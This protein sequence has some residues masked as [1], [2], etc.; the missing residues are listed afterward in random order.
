MKLLN[1]S[2]HP[3]SG[4]SEEQKR[5]WKVFDIPFPAVPAEAGEAEVASLANSIA[6]QVM[7][8]YRRFPF[9]A[10]TIQGEFSLCY[11]LLGKLAKWLSANNISIA[12]PT[13]ERKVVG[14]NGKKVSE[15]EFVR[16]RMLSPAFLFN[17][18]EVENE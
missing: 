5:G 11:L 14:K 7:E 8:L 16:W 15:F 2:N 9:D 1:I 10:I 6:V 13:T 3:S 17:Q 4:W 12:I 18:K